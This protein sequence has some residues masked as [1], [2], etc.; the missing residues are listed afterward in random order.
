[1]TQ[2]RNK[3][4]EAAWL[5]HGELPSA[6]IVKGTVVDVLAMWDRAVILTGPVVEIIEAGEQP[7]A[8]VHLEHHFRDQ[9]IATSLK[10][11]SIP[12]RP[13]K[14]RRYIVQRR[15]GRCFVY[16]EDPGAYRFFPGTTKE[17]R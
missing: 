13:S 12:S 4:W 6:K 17:E 15:P 11:V 14:Y 3:V 5:P 7:P 8:K 2:L 1:M 16:P 9:N 10:R